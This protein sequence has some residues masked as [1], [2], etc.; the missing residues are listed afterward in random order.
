MRL[1]KYSFLLIVSLLTSSLHWS[2][3]AQTGQATPAKS[4]AASGT[5][6][7][8]K[9]ATPATPA[10]GN[11]SNQPIDLNRPYCDAYLPYSFSGK[12]IQPII[13]SS[14]IKTISDAS[15]VGFLDQ[16]E[17][18]ADPISVDGSFKDPGYPVFGDPQRK[19]ASDGSD[20][21]RVLKRLTGVDAAA[22]KGQTESL[23]TAEVPKSSTPTQRP[24]DSD[25]VLVHIVHWKRV[26]GAYQTASSDWYLFNKADAKAAHREF[27][28]TFHPIVNEQD[29]L[30]IF[31]SN[32][33]FFLA[34]HL[35]PTVDPAVGSAPGTSATSD[36]DNFSK[37]V[38]V[39]YK[40]NVTDV[41]PANIQ[42]LKALI[43]IVVGP[44]ASTGAAKG[45]G[46]A[47][48]PVISKQEIDDYKAFLDT[49]GTRTYD[50]LYTAAKLT[51]LN[52]LPV[53]ITATM[54]ADLP[55]VGNVPGN[56]SAH[57]ESSKFWDDIKLK[58]PNSQRSA[59]A[60]DTAGCTTVGNTGTCPESL[61]VQ[62][63]GLYWWDV[64]VGIPFTSYKQLNYDYSTAGQVTTQTVSKYSAYAFF[65]LAPWKE[66]IVSPPSLG[67]PHL[68]FGLPFTGSVLNHPF[69]GAGETFNVSKLPN[70]GPKISKVVPFGIR[71]YAGLV[72]NKEYG[73]KPA[74]GNAQPSYKWVGK[75]QY[76]LEFS[77]RDI[78]NKL[79][80]SKKPTTTSKATSSAAKN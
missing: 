69:V 67:I 40:L 25:Y 56:A 34:I 62:N 24:D 63:E 10:K 35:A 65:V 66:D 27:P 51:N 18:I 77:V 5:S 13:T 16:N 46:A 33:V 48:A 29:P 61:T 3:S 14:M 30:R 15:I 44:A 38:K 57:Y 17:S 54:N 70:I 55:K 4:K 7:Q 1:A 45:A 74:T 49:F 71:F 9:P 11:T 59:A 64:S 37:N 2:A 79:S 47:P 20:L 76:G 39:S 60:G 8:A 58:K 80:S 21:V 28:F 78:A 36:Y 42:D 41:V 75:L 53:Q 22:G 32:K 52:S 31:G 72:E 73:P 26:S 43:G 6:K 68:L 19:F 50:G 12:D 23:C